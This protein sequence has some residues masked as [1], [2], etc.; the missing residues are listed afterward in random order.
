[1]AR[2][3]GCFLFVPRPVPRLHNSY[4]LFIGENP[5]TKVT[6]ILRSR[7][8]LR[9]RP[10][11]LSFRSHDLLIIYSIQ[12]YD[13]FVYFYFFVSLGVLKCDIFNWITWN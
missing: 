5:V 8:P 4:C 13:L 1:M 2:F 9:I 10:I 3:Y 6:S 11:T 12:M 7:L